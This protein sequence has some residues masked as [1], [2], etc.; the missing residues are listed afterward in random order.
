MSKSPSNRTAVILVMMLVIGTWI[1]HGRLL[2]AEAESPAAS[3]P[4]T[5][6]SP[7][8]APATTRQAPGGDTSRILTNFANMMKGNWK[9][10]AAF[11]ATT[12]LNAV[13]WAIGMLLAGILAGLASY[14]ILRRFRLFDATWPWYRFVRWLWPVVFILGAAAG[15]TYSGAWIGL[16][17]NIKS[18]IREK[19]MLDKIVGQV[20]FAIVLDKASYQTTGQESAEKLEQVLADSEA[21]G[22]LAMADW[23]IARE[24][25]TT[26][27]AGS[28]LERWLVQLALRNISD[29]LAEQFGSMDPR[30]MMVFIGTHPNIDQYLREHPD[31][32]PMIAALSVHFEPVRQKGCDMVDSVVHPHAAVGIAAGLLGPALLLGIFCVVVHLA[33]G[34]PGRSR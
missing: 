33:G 14:F 2:A 6:S 16:G 18:Y 32:N 29:E 8:S 19:R 21:I 3:Q 26:D 12:V 7:A 27:A 9:S 22:E 28:P 10:L 34:R 11:A 5:A 23:A 13:L 30:L 25:L 1:A 31:A 20:Y 4:T 24:E 15:F 17:R